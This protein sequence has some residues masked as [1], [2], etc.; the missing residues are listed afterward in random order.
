M[1]L[2]LDHLA[3]ILTQWILAPGMI[4]ITMVIENMRP[5]Q[6][7]HLVMVTIG[8]V[9]MIRK[10]MTRMTASTSL[11]V[12]PKPSLKSQMEIG[13]GPVFSNV[14]SFYTLKIGFYKIYL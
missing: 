9:G 6:R 8:R 14:S 7:R 2:P 1:V 13:L 5:L 12:K 4:G 3:E 11:M 10:M